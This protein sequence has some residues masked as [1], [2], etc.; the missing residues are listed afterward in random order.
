M[1]HQGE[2]F[3]N[4]KVELDGQEFYACTFENCVMAYGGGPPPILN[5][6]TLGGCRWIFVGAADRTLQF[7]QAMFHGGFQ[8]VVE[9]TFDAIRTGSLATGANLS[10]R[11]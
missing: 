7:M 11:P 9:Q 10:D 8:D 1:K 4:A 6:C 2:T 3:T 5:G